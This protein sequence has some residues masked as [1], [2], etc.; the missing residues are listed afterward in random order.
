MALAVNVALHSNR[1]PRPDGFFNRSSESLS[2]TDFFETKSTC[3]NLDVVGLRCVPILLLAAVPCWPGCRAG[4]AAGRAASS[5]GRRK[6]RR[7]GR[8]ARV[9]RGFSRDPECMPPGTA[10]LDWATPRP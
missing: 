9:L 8:R 7:A 6:E 5:A 4:C 3:D 10:I 1:D 2:R